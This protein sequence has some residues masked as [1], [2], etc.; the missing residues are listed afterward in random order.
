MII[1]HTIIAS[2]HTYRMTLILINLAEQIK[3]AM[4]MMMMIQVFKELNLQYFLNLHFTD[5]VNIQLKTQ[6]SQILLKYHRL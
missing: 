3:I 2:L 1:I 5:F 6:Y 4:V